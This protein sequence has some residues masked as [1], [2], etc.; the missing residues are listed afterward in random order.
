MIQRILFS[1]TLFMIILGTVFVEAQVPTPVPPDQRGRAD[2]ERRGTLDGNNMR[3]E[4]WNYGMVGNY[5][6]DPINVDLSVFHSVEVPKG[7]GMNYSDGVTPFVLA[8][9]QQKNGS[10]AYIMETGFRERQGLSVKTGR[11]MRFE[12]RPG[13]FQADPAINAG[14][15]PAI[16]N[17]PRTWPASWPDK[18]ATWD[19][20]WNGYFGQRPAADLESFTVMDDNYYDA[21]DFDPDSRDTTR[22]G[23]G[24]RVEVRGFQW[25]NPQAGNVIFWHYD[26]TNEGTTDYNDNIIFGLYMDSGVG[27]SAV[28]CDGIAESDDDNAFFDRSQ[29]LNLVYTWDRRGHGRDL[30]GNCSPTGYVGYAYLETPGKPEDGIDND[31]DGVIDERR[32]SGPGQLIVGQDAILAYVQATYNMTAFEAFY[33]S[34]EDRPAY[35]A[36]RWW[37]GDEDMDWV[38]DLH[39]VGADGVAETNDTGEGDGI[40]MEGEPNFDRTDLHESDQIGLTGFKFSRIRSLEGLPTDNVVFFTN[41]NNW[42]E[43]LYQQFSA[44]DENIRFDNALAQNFNIA[45]LFASG[46]FTLRAGQTERFSLALSYG[47]DLFELE[48]TVRVVQAIYNANYQFATPPPTP[49]ITAETGDGYVQLSW[50][51]AAENSFDAIAGIND[52]EGYRIYRS[53]DPE[54]RDPKIIVTGRGTS[55][56]GHGKPIAQYDLVNDRRGYTEQ[57]VEGVAYY[58]GNESG[59]THTF[60]DTT[61]TNGQLYYYAVTSYDYGPTIPGGGFTYYPSESPISVSRTL[62][63]GLILPTNV[64]AVRPNP[65]ALGFIRASADS[66]THISGDGTGSVAV[67]VVNS[68]IVPDGHTLK[69]TF[70]TA[71]SSAIRAERYTLTD[72]TTGEVLFNSGTTLD[73]TPSGLSG[74]GVLPVIETLPNVIVDSATTGFTSGSTTN[75]TLNV[76]YLNVMPINLRR[77]AF[78]DDI[79]ITFYDTFVDTST[80]IVPQPARPA[81]FRIIAHTPEGDKQLDFKF[82]DISIGGIRDG[83]LTHVTGNA[84]YIHILTGPDSLPGAQRETWR[85]TLSSDSTTTPP[86]QGDVFELKLQRPFGTEDVF[87]FTTQGEKVD[88]Q[89]AKQQANNE[90]PYVVP[91]PYVAS[92]SFEPERF[93]VSGRGERRMEF[94]SLPQFA[95]VRIYTVRGDLVQTLR[96]DGSAEGYVA[97][98][99]RTKD[100]LEIA[101]G[102]YIFHVEA[103]GTDAYIGKFAVIK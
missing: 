28:S 66:A 93:A 15:S 19:G 5:P 20:E 39:D 7:S 91:N 67:E 100:N 59:L 12:P 65:K 77:E 6:A 71:D 8:R 53:T 69:L 89:Q 31:N 14:R 78:P 37:T 55:P 92:A 62:R 57:A 98:D 81:K 25:S 44:P 51:D 74:V 58:L 29:G 43:R 36:A 60:R 26:I 38:R 35:Q 16:S 52:F 2:A 48:T 63:G 97:W 13:Y 61:V 11:T 99:L 68:S 40:P 83:T 47:A 3:T 27:G 95:T 23:L 41:E 85:I 79:T 46:P 103:P 54:F 30:A 45:F 101:A 4:F 22:R 87:V 32:E 88:A 102:L 18:D 72:S 96:H 94:R 50:D 70:Q 34:L 1:V 86:K 73:G 33:G 84:E 64:V 21:W 9:V 42:P 10:E 82:F 90:K 24:L 49:T 80:A 17:D 76:T 56:I 75:A